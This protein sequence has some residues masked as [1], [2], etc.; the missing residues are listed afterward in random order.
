[1][2]RW[3]R[4]NPV[5]RFTVG[6]SSSAYRTHGTVSG[7]QHTVSNLRGAT[8]I[9]IPAVNISSTRP[10]VRQTGV[11]GSS[12]LDDRNVWGR[13]GFQTCQKVLKRGS[14]TGNLYAAFVLPTSSAKH[15][16][17]QAWVCFRLGAGNLGRCIHSNCPLLRLR[18][19]VGNRG[20]PETS[21]A[22]RLDWL[23]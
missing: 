21:G 13:D 11:S 1:M 19:F 3:V 22:G 7:R 18:C 2:S 15:P 4:L 17:R 8:K 10:Q 9:P 23:P 20:H 5:R 16:N 12:V 6:K 14:H